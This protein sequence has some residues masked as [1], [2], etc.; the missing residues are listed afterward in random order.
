MNAGKDTPNE[1]L[2]NL[3]RKVRLP[4]SSPELKDRI[5]AE[6]TRVWRQ[7]SVELSWRV[8]FMRL[9]TSVAAT[10]FVIWL[11]N[12]ASDSSLARWQVG[13]PSITSQQP[14]ELDLFPEMPDGPF[15]RHLTSISRKYPATDASGLRHYIETVRR[16]LDEAQQN[17]ASKSSL[18][19]EDTSRLLPGRSSL[20]SYS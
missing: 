5:T 19:L 18:P 11:A 9:V 6:A 7:A 1:Q 12:V 8:P 16:L 10:V 13:G 3:L 14:S 15:V 20:N 17:S 4:E 2:E